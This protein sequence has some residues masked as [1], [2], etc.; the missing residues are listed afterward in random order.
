M[1]IGYRNRRKTIKRLRKDYQSEETDM[2]KFWAV[3]HN[4]QWSGVAAR[5]AL[6]DRG[7]TV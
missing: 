6:K 4:D 7:V 3:E 2:L 1:S 5:L